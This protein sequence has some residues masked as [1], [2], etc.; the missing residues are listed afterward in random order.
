MTAKT[1]GGPGLA[2]FLNVCAPRSPLLRFSKIL[3]GSLDR[4]VDREAPGAP[5]PSLR[6]SN[7]RDF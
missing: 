5:A 2:E 1:P 6:L 4:F 3:A 7:L